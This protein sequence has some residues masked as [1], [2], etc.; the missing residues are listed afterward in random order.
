M[1]ALVF[2]LALLATAAPAAPARRLHAQAPPTIPHR[3]DPQTACTACHGPERQGGVPGVP[4]TAGGFC[5]SCHV[6]QEAT[7]P[8]RTNA[9][10]GEVPSRARGRR[11]HLGA[12]PSL[13]HPVFMREHCLACHGRERHPGLRANP[14]PDRPNCASCHISG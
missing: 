6:P 9:F 12:P 8:Y 2:G 14:H 7:A 1:R 10:K 4:H 3:V 5:Q 13:P 11:P